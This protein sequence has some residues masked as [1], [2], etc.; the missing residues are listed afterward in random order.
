MKALIV[1]TILMFLFLL[2][3]TFGAKNQDMITVNFLIAE[4]QTQIPTLLSLTFLAGFLLAWI[5]ASMWIMHLKIKVTQTTRLLQ[6]NKQSTSPD[7]DEVTL[8]IEN[9]TT[10]NA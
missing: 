3:F 10:K 5:F 7:K 2:S 1:S 9:N 4:I 6:K 8:S